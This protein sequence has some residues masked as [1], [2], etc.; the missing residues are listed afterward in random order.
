MRLT[1]FV[2][3]GLLNLLSYI[4]HNHLPMGGTTHRKLDPP[5]FVVN[6]KKNLNEQTDKTLHSLPTSQA[7]RDTF[8]PIE[9]PSFQTT[10]PT[11]CQADIKLANP[12][13][14]FSVHETGKTKQTAVQ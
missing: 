4:T 3:P 14:Q 10:L 11:L 8:F 2:P 6:L 7:G 1:D 5:I 12:K 9:L 13:T